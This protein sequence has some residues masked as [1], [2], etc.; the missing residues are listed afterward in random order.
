MSVR[1]DSEERLLVLLAWAFGISVD[2]AYRMR[3]VRLLMR[4]S[5]SLCGSSVIRP[6]YK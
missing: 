4:A 2:R 3:L 5:A 6:R 1:Y